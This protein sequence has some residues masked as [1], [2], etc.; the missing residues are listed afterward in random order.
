ML[1][2]ARHSKLYDWISGL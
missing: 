2:K 1:G